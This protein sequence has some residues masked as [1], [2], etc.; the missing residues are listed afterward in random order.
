MTVQAPIHIMEQASYGS[1]S[2][3]TIEP[4]IRPTPLVSGRFS[5]PHRK[6]SRATTG[7]VPWNL[8][9]SAKVFLLSLFLCDSSTLSPVYSFVILSPSTVPALLDYSR[10]PPIRRRCIIYRRTTQLWDSEVPSSSTTTTTTISQS[11]GSIQFQ[12][13]A[14]GA[15]G[16]SSQVNGSSNTNSNNGQ[17][18]QRLSSKS[19]SISISNQQFSSSSN[20]TPING[21]DIPRPT[22]NGGYSHT[23]ASRAKISA[24]NR[25]KTPWNKGKARSDEVR[26]RIS[27]G[28]RARNRERLLQKIANMGLTED[29]YE[30]QKKAKRRKR[31]AERRARKTANGGYTPTDA[32]RAKIS[33]SLKEVHASGQVKKRQVDLTKVRRGFT[34]SEE[35]R[36][37]ISEALKKKWR[38]DDNYREHMQ[39][40][41]SKM[42]SKEETR[43]K[44][45][46]ALKKKWEDPEFREEMTKKMAERRS[47]GGSNMKYDDSYRKKI[48]DAMKKKWQDP[49]YRKKTLSSIQKSALSRPPTKIAQRVK[50]KKTVKRKK[51]VNV[52]MQLIQPLSPADQVL[53]REK[54]M[55]KKQKKDAA[56]AEAAAVEPLEPRR[57]SPSTSKIKRA[58]KS[59]EQLSVGKV[60]EEVPKK[61][62]VKAKAKAKSERKQKDD[63]NVLRLKEERRDLFDLLYGDEDVDSVNGS[64]QGVMLQ[65][66]SDDEEDSVLSKMGIIFGDEDLD[67][68][69]PYGLDDY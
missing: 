2:V 66:I 35:T 42:N 8:S 31:E 1:S 9:V 65:R 11:S 48:S 33:K 50:K 64:D 34:H 28:V 44:I 7:S 69:D 10:S 15:N 63:G 27:A 6:R 18:Q 22:A 47:T 37:K 29:Q 68:F 56:E 61:K 52:S 26:A 24:A 16:I 51:E 4:S 58:T 19:P 5:P 67:S 55:A 41:S 54:S 60:L 45:S 12:N 17:Q 14:A 13:G 39:E 30:A 38:D 59:V 36:R 21:L 62:K 20:N 40:S 3:E 23:N 53:R 32:T 49:E 25:G 57:A 46:E 43:R